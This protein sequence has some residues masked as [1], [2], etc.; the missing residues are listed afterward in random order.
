MPQRSSGPI[1]PQGNSKGH[2]KHPSILSQGLIVGHGGGGTIIVTVSIIRSVTVPVDS[3][4]VLVGKLQVPVVLV[5]VLVR[6]VVR[7]ALVVV[8]VVVSTVL[9]TVVVAPV[10]VVNGQ[11]EI[12]RVLSNII[13]LISS[14]REV[15][16]MVLATTDTCTVIVNGSVLIVRK[17]WVS[18]EVELRTRVVVVLV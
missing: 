14:V 17:D 12:V 18:V 1:R 9:V 15:T 5:L 3:T 7:L 11:D 2:V 16:L 10:V 13:E 4:V 8:P 6:V